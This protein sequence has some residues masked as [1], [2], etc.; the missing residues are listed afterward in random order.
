MVCG[1]SDTGVKKTANKTSDTYRGERRTRGHDDSTACLVGGLTSGG[2]RG[3]S[4]TTSV[5]NW[6]V[7]V[8]FWRKGLTPLFLAIEFLPQP[9][10]K[11]VSFIRWGHRSSRHR[12]LTTPPP[13]DSRHFIHSDWLAVDWNGQSV[14]ISSVHGSGSSTAEERAEAVVVRSPIWWVPCNYP[15]GLLLSPCSCGRPEQQQN[16]GF[17]GI[18]AITLTRQSA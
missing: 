18:A 2:C 13:S 16:D 11:Q 17:T 10:Q 12:W 15:A 14:I 3:W 8:A 6:G 9:P 4:L 7:Q 5:R 1:N